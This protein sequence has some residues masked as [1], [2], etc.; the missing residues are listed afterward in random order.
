MQL[1][2]G[3]TAVEVLAVR[4]DAGEEVC[5]SLAQVVGDLDLA[6]GVVLTGCGSLEHIH[7]E[8]PVTQTWPSAVIDVD[9][10]GPGQILT[11]QGHVASGGLELYLT[12][13]RRNETFA[14]KAMPGT[15]VLHT[16]ELSILRVGNTRWARV[17]HPETGIPQLQ[18]VTASPPVSVTLMG[19]PVDP[20]AVAA[21]PQ[22]LMRKHVCLPVAK[23]PDTLVVAMTDPSNPF[24][25]EELREATGLRIQ[26]V[27]VPAHELLPAL[28]KVVSG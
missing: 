23:S 15:R 11:A 24:A 2:R 20:N 18:A 10:Q 4:L 21:V 25:I 19:R 3:G 27:A 26:T 16:V 13:A 8:V 6:A 14:G 5:A 17:G 12:V 22:A 9:K 1:F 28:Q 7:L